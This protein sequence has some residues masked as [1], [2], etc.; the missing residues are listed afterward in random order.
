MYRQ[1]ARADRDT[2][3]EKVKI[4]DEFLNILKNKPIPE[5]KSPEQLISSIFKELT[6]L[7]WMELALLDE[8]SFN[9]QK[10]SYEGDHFG[11]EDLEFLTTTEFLISPGYNVSWVDLKYYVD[12]N[13]FFDW[14]DQMEVLLQEPEFLLYV[15][16]LQKG[17]ALG[18][19][20][21]T[22]NF[23]VTSIVSDSIEEDRIGIDTE[24]IPNKSRIE[25]ILSE[26]GYSYT[27]MEDASKKLIVESL[28]KTLN[29]EFLGKHEISSEILSYLKIHP[30]TPSELKALIEL[31]K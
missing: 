7:I 11:P 1:E 17:Q 10:D 8:I 9:Y 5:I 26:K 31:S 21:L 12:E 19:L 18:H 27:N 2:N 6:E 20:N 14:N 3:N 15:S 16:G 30:A 28:V 24:V 23:N 25:S 4:N 13:E 29:H 22:N